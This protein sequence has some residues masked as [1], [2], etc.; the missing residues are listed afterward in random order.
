VQFFFRFVFISV[1]VVGFVGCVA[2]TRS[3]EIDFATPPH[4]AQPPPQRIDADNE[5]AWVSTEPSFVLVDK[6]CG[7]V[8]LYTYG[9]LTKTY[10]AVFGRSPGKKSHE[11][12][13]RT[14]SG[15]YMIV[16]KNQHSRW[17]RFLSLDYP[18]VRDQILYW[19]SLEEG[20]IPRRFNGYPGPG[21]AIGIHGTDNE[22]FNRAKIN[23]TL[24]C[25]S[26]FNKDV[27][28]LYNLTA[29]GTWVYIKE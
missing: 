10:P 11:G 9:H 29:V 21:G 22:A 26:L 23:W 25:I 4:R 13:L 17:S 6:N 24:G 2:P 28:E 16:D 20:K 18:N 1:I 3:P 12:D 19:K 27:Q 5:L 7:T 14:P 15:L 8:N